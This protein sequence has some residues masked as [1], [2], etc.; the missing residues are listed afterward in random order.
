MPLLEALGRLCRE[1]GGDRLITLL[2]QHAPIWLVQLPT[3]LTASEL[4][5]LQRKVQGATRER[6]LRGMTEAVDAITTE[7]PLV[8][9]LED[10]HWS[11]VS[12]LELL[13][14]LARRREPARLLVIG[15]YRPV[16]MLSDGH[17]LKRVTQELFA[18]SLGKELQLK[19]LTEVEVTTYL[20]RRFPESV[21]PTRLGQ[22]LYQRTGGTPLFLTSMV[23]D[24][25][26][27]HVL[28]AGVD[29]RWEFHA[30]I[31]E[32]E[33][34]T[35]ETARYLLA[36]QRERL[37][38]TDQRLL[39]A[40][41]LASLE[42]STA[43]VAAALETEVTQ[44]E[45]QCGRLAEQQ[46][47]LR[48][49]GISEWPDGTRAARYGFLHALC[50]EFW[51]EQVQVGQQQQWHLRM[52]ERQ[53]AAYGQRTKEIATELALH[54]AE[55]RDYHRAVRYLQQ[56]AET[57]IQRS[58]HQEAI[59]H[60]TKG[61][62]LLQTL[63]DTSERTQ[64]ELG[65]QITIGEPLMA[66]KG[67][68]A[69]EVEKTYNRV[70]ML[71]QQVGES[72]ELFP[73]LWGLWAFHHIRG[74]LETAREVAEQFLRL[75]E[76][77]QDSILIV[78]AHYM[79]GETLCFLGELVLARVHLEQEIVLS[80]P[81]KH[82]H[83]Q[84]P[85]IAR[86]F[87]TALALWQLGYPDQALE[88][89]REALSLAQELDNPFTLALA[90]RF[91]AGLQL[92]NLDGQM[93][94]EQAEAL[95]ALSTEQ[96]FSYRA[97]WGIML[98][99]WALSEQ[100]REEEGIA[101]IQQG[102]AAWRA[103]GAGQGLPTILTLLASAYA[104]GGRVEEGLT[105][106][107]EALAVVDKTGECMGEAA[108]YVLKGWLLLARSKEN[109]AETEACFLHAIE[110]AR[111]Q[112][113]KMWELR[114]TVSLARLWQQRGKRHKAHQMLSEIYNWF[115]EGFDTKDLQ[116]AKALLEELGH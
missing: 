62:E 17:P 84:D 23:Q 27:Q 53:E 45:T 36:R 98:R 85:G 91:A 73:V 11:D 43:T 48:P 8:L 99:G 13:A 12:T 71:C 47:F 56:A 80:E 20:T 35:P 107:E 105:S 114:A 79:L 9:W 101:Q 92:C 46:Q 24:V 97:A 31:E 33:T 65:L 2:N 15:A 111:H 68:A 64:Q 109:H 86:L 87:D 3:L 60:L 100:G 81:Q 16:E 51:H 115:T 1:P 83:V 42:F 90:L 49:A 4:E 34:R 58:A 67:Y 32:I 102:P 57:A 76:S 94:Q 110:I 28:L 70:L 93:V 63:P 72:P 52:G 6:M 96:G 108:L 103:T 37:A 7:R 82:H 38:T 74:E 77:V 78:E 22:V 116:E 104:K 69:Q 14:L 39:E 10:L 21:L 41:S 59:T 25:L 30:T 29:G 19:S 112:Q 89:G 54:F 55:G 50:Q 5:A 18:H 26:S 44:V 95:I 40:A 106:L 113:A 75:A 88:K 66:V 61:L